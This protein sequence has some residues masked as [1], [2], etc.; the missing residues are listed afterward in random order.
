MSHVG[1][2][3]G[4]WSGTRRR[5]RRGRRRRGWCEWTR[6]WRRAS[7]ARS[8]GPGSA[9]GPSG[10]PCWPA[11]GPPSPPSSAPSAGR[12]GPDPPPRP[13]PPRAAVRVARSVEGGGAVPGSG[14][15]HHRGSESRI[16]D[17]SHVFRIRVTDS[18]STDS[19]LSPVPRSADRVG[20]PLGREPLG[21]AGS[22]SLSPSTSSPATACGR[23]GACCVRRGC[24]SSW[25]RARAR[26]GRA[27][28]VRYA[29]GPVQ[30]R[31]RTDS[32][33][34][35]NGAKWRGARVLR[36]GR[37]AAPARRGSGGDASLPRPCGLTLRRGERR[38]PGPA[39]VAW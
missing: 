36:A 31:M 8:A 16:P 19:P 39:R 27:L 15:L 2:G 1:G 14:S 30:V 4:C 7:R 22:D 9:S 23:Q 17:P 10:P 5:W 12:A 18:H 24:T 34:C 25:Y 28:E 21:P 33:A 32:H 37:G 13:P 20:P 35:R 26:A 11:P 38:G 3:R 6:P 29:C